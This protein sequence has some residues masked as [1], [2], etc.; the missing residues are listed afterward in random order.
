M[1]AITVGSIPLLDLHNESN[2]TRKCS[3]IVGSV[4]V[5]DL[6]DHG[7]NSWKYNTTGP[8]IVSWCF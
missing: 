8:T 4:T 1:M 6:L 5:L 7:N 2:N 3:T